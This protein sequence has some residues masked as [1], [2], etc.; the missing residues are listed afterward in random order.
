MAVFGA[1]G[2]P[3]GGGVAGD[4]FDLVERVLNVGLEVFAAGDVFLEEGVAGE[5]GKERLHVQVFAPGEEFE[6]ADAVGGAVGPRRGMRGAVDE[7]AD[8]LLPFVVLVE[9]IAFR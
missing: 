3:A 1:L 4:V 8:G 6:Q 2:S 7:R 5:D 9:V